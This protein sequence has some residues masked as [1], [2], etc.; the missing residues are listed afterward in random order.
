[1]DYMKIPTDMLFSIQMLDD[2]ERGRLFSKMLVYAQTG[3]ESGLLKGNER[4]LWPTAKLYI[5]RGRDA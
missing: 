1:M 5:N 4:F 2:A 3:G